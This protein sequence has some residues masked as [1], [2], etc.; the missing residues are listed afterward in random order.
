MEERNFRI[1]FFFF[2]SQNDE[3]VSKYEKLFFRLISKKFP[4]QPHFQLRV[5]MVVGKQTWAGLS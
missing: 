2:T 5:A 4:M 3:F 1:V